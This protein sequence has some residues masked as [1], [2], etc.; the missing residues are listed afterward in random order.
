[1][2]DQPSTKV[3]GYFQ[4]PLR[5]NGCLAVQPYHERTTSPTGLQLY[6]QKQ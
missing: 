1:M 5:D 2:S 3:L 6:R 4:E